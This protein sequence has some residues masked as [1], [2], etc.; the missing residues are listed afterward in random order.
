MSQAGLM[1]QQTPSR[2]LVGPYSEA[3]VAYLKETHSAALSRAREL[4]STA[5]MNGLGAAEMCAIHHESLRE[6]GVQIP[7]A[8]ADPQVDT[9]TAVS[10][11]L[12]ESLR[13]F[14]TSQNE[15]RLMNVALRRQNETLEGDLRRVSRIIF[16]EA[17][18]L[19]SATRL[20]LAGSDQAPPPAVWNLLERLEEQLA[21]CS[22]S[23]QPRML[24][25]LGLASAIQ[26]LSRRFATACQLDVITEATVGPLPPQVSIALYRSVLEALTNVQRHARASR[27]RIRLCEECS[28][29]QCSIRDDGIGFDISRALSEAEVQGSGFVFIQE[30][31]RLVGGTLVVDSVPGGGTELRISVCP[32]VQ[33]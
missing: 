10:A 30:S 24:E 31:L 4:G 20:A 29:I 1:A 16:D 6:I 23:L 33:D 32:R 28:M 9:V 26:F 5:L 22:G 7:R 8:A 14:E 12:A 27:V 11:F 25:D 13:V 17:L 19:V 2:E 3:L 15:L 18:Q 21:S